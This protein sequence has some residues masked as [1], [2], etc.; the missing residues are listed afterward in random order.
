MSAS[1]KIE[2][3]ECDKMLVKNISFPLSLEKE[4]E[5]T[6]VFVLGCSQDEKENLQLMDYYTNVSN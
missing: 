1:E 2:K 3:A 5:K 6:L 4:E